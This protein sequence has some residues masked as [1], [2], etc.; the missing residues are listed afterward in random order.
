MADKHIDFVRHVVDLMQ[1]VGPVSYRRMF[2]GFGL[3]LDGCMLAIIVDGDLFLRVDSHCQQAFIDQGLQPFIYYK[4]KKPI[5]L[6]Y[7][8]AP[9]ETLESSD[10]MSHWANLAVGAAFRVAAEKARVSA[11]RTGIKKEQG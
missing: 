4:Q 1:C 9:E 3:F 8:Q 6:P 10:N 11:K 2:G 5:K 7:F